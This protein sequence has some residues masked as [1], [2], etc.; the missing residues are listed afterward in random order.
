[1]EELRK[2]PDIVTVGRHLEF[3]ENCIS[4]R[5]S[6]SARFTSRD[7][8]AFSHSRIFGSMVRVLLR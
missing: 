1:M 6:I 5:G 8:V 2:P 7:S 3:R 4:T